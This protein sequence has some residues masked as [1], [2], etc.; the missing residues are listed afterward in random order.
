[1]ALTTKLEF[2]P[3]PLSDTTPTWYDITSDLVSIE[4][5]A[6][7]TEDLADP[8]PGG[9]SCLLN[10][11]NRR[12]EPDYVA[13]AFYPN[14]DTERRFRLTLTDATGA[15]QQGVWYAESWNLSYPG[16]NA[17]SQVT[18]TA[19][20]GT[21]L[22][23]NDTLPLLDPPDASSYADVVAYDQPSFYYRLGEPEGTKLVSHVRKGRRRHYKHGPYKGTT[24]IWRDKHWKTVETKAGVEGQAGPEGTYKGNPLLAQPGAILGDPDMAVKFR[25]SSNEYARIA[26][27]ESDLIDRN[28]L[29]LE[30]WVKPT[31]VGSFQT[32]ISG[33]VS[34]A[35]GNISFSLGMTGAGKPSLFLLFTSAS[36]SPGWTMDGDTTMSAGTWYH[37]VGT[38]DGA[39][40]RIFVDGV[41]DKGENPPGADS[42]RNGDA[43]SHVSIGRNSQGADYANATLDEVAIYEKQLS[44][45]RIAA[46]YIAGTARGY[47]E[48]LTGVRIASIASSPLWS[49]A[50]IDG[51]VFTMQETMQ[52]GQGKFDEIVEA[53]GA[54]RPRSLFFFDGSG[55]PIYRDFNYLDGETTSTTLG[56]VAGEVRYAALDLIYDNE[57][58]NTVTGSTDG[59][60]AITVTDD[61]S[62]SDRKARTRDAESNL[63]LRDDVDVLTIVNTI[64]SEWSRP[65]QRP[66]SVSVLGADTTRISHILRRT[67]GDRARVKRRGEGGTPIDRQTVILGYR[68]ALD[69]NR[70]LSC[71]W[72]MARGF[73]AGDGDW[74]LGVPGFTELGTTTVLG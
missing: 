58:Y 69:A 55:N 59:G 10:N 45:S 65:A 6:G 15:V 56:D 9:M 16:G 18:V 72:N 4:W 42:L 39:R 1:M 64:V 3:D 44:A 32:F 47:D 19:V 31:T 70:I 67:I 27:D 12:F 29:T 48:E 34:T 57:V 43:G 40:M 62:I 30:V 41:L 63:P 74:H 17:F 14:I 25:S 66:A 22:L 33:P 20:D 13:G 46:H 73:N 38:W 60:S 71:T 11:T 35:G 26:V 5:W 21:G 37:L 24:A 54:E 51:G 49:T 23:T 52:F 36:G 61:A 2:S 7:K 8:E 50:G 28:V 68:K 53:V